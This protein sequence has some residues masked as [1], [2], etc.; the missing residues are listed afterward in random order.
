VWQ[1]GHDASAGETLVGNIFIFTVFRTPTRATP[2]ARIHLQISF[3][4]IR[5]CCGNL[6]K[7]EGRDRGSVGGEIAYREREG[8][9]RR[10]WRRGECSK[11]EV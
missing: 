2:T 10:R 7:I 4:R 6:F 3:A 11:G 1:Y 8:G 5:Y 9:W